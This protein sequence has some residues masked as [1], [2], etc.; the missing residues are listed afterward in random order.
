MLPFGRKPVLIFVQVGRRLLC[1]VYCWGRDE[2]VPR[3]SFSCFLIELEDSG[4][5]AAPVL[6]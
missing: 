4:A 2:K 3:V 6:N 1:V 5:P